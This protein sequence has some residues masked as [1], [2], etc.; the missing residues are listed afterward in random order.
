MSVCDNLS[1]LLLTTYYY[2]KMQRHKEFMFR[3]LRNIILFGISNLHLITVYSTDIIIITLVQ[4]SWIEYAPPIVPFVYLWGMV[5]YTIYKQKLK[6]NQ[7]ERNH[8]LF[9]FLEHLLIGPSILI[10]IL[11]EER[12]FNSKENQTLPASIAVILKQ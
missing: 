7:N 1:V 3:F 11:T 5:F 9:M 2:C 8:S 10:Q 12:Y 4:D 6:S